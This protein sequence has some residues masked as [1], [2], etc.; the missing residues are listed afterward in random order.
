[1]ATRQTRLI[2]KNS[3]T[4]NQPLSGATALKG[5]AVVNL[6]DGILYYSGASG[7][8]FVSSDN[9]TS[10]FFEVGSNLY[11]LKIRDKITSYSGVTNLSGQ[12]LS[13]TSTGFVLAPIS[14]IQGVDRHVTGFTYDPN[15]NSFTI[16]QS[17][18]GPT[19]T[20]SFDSV[21]GLTINGNLTV[22]GNT[23]LSSIT[24][25]STTINGNL[26][27]TGNTNLSGTT[28]YDETVSGTNP[29]EII[30]L[31]YL[32]GY[33]QTTDVYV[34]G[35]TYTPATNDTD[36]TSWLLQYHGT[37]IGSPHSFSG[38][39]TFVTG[40]TYSLGTITFNYNDS[41]KPAFTVTGID[42][43]DTYVTGG[44]I[45][46]Y[47]STSNITGQTQLSYNNP[48]AGG[49]YYLPYSDVFVTGFTY[50]NNTFT[51]KDNSG[52]TYSDVINTVTGLTVNGNLTVTGL[53][54]NRVVYTTTGG[55]LT[56]E[57]NFGYND[58]TDTLSVQNIDASG[59]VTVQ[60]S[61]T[62]FGPSISAFTTNLYVEDPNIYLNYNP[63]GSTTVTSV[64]AGFTIQDGNGVSS[65]DVNFDIIR[66]QNLTGLTSN[67]VPNV[68]EYTSPTGYS[69]RGWIT[70]LNDIVIRSTDVTDEIT[71]PSSINGVRV[72][73]EFD[74]LD[75]GQY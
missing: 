12:F 64:N 53:G 23:V 22:T 42:G 11:Q 59:D 19:K 18:G 71:P 66:L 2:T 35:A 15:T 21:S 43:T 74:V 10:G 30:N 38:E 52:N 44:T 8:G 5:E 32:T 16:T 69:N 65:G 72:L 47:P 34:T 68:S 17:E 24:G 61:L 27:V 6:F 28:L 20:A 41:G 46:T 25:G 4:S 63:T 70:Q 29:L 26:T 51:I 57:S 45:S 40:G 73:A 55:L 75:G 49:P 7:G 9:P 60:G 14:S 56:T 50:S 31:N 58:G 3:L 33:V 37:P 67:N 48:E 36:Y 54:T 1:M 62:V 39:N 13:G